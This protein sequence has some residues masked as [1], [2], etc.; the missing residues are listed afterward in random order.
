[1]QQDAQMP[2][3][4]RRALARVSRLCVLDG[5]EDLGASIHMVMGLAGRPM[6]DWGIP[7]FG[8]S[9]RYR[10]VELADGD[11]GVPTDDCREL[12][13]MGGREI[14]IS[15]ELHHEQLRAAVQG[16]PAAQRHA[17]YTA[18]RQFVVRNP[19]VSVDALHRFITGGH[20]HGARAISGQFRPI[21]Q[22]A[23]VSG[24][25]RM[26]GRCGSLLWPVTDPGFPEGRCQVRQCAAAGET[27]IGREIEE[28]TL[29]RLATAPVL[30][31]WVGPGLD[32]IALYDALHDRRLNAVLYPLSDAADVGIDGLDVGLDVKNYSSP[33]VLGTRLSNGIG[34]LAMFK[35]RIIVVPDY[36]LRLNRRYLEDLT[37]AYT[38]GERLE[39][40]TV[41]KVLNEFVS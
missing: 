31:F 7:S 11:L 38:G 33:I 5:V 26:C 2:P 10:D 39:F 4:A 22:G 36:K 37:A 13:R 17:A 27:V 29:H 23:I 3:I 28:P 12:A 6:S 16:Y 14:D 35:R 41:S 15:E 20:V 21:P 30:A 32:E 40:T 9:F 34:R 24:R 8:G 25:A 1:V 18:I 19:V